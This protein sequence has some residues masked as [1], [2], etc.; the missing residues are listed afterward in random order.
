MYDRLIFQVKSHVR[1]VTL[2]HG[3]VIKHPRRLGELI[4]G[5]IKAISGAE[6]EKNPS[7]RQAASSGD[8]SASRDT[9]GFG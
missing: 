8:S 9:V 1:Y 5:R 2:I 6:T 3:D 7:N 4:V